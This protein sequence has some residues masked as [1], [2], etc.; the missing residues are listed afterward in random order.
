MKTLQ[1]L[2]VFFGFAYFASILASFYFIQIPLSKR[3]A[4][5][6]QNLNWSLWDNPGILFLIGLNL[7]IPICSY[8]HAMKKSYIA[9][10][11][12]LIVGGFFAFMNIFALLIGTTFEGHIWIGISPTIFASA[13]MVL[14]FTNFI[15]YLNA[16]QQSNQ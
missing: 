12:I 2:E 6:N 3:I 8:L 13:T 14:A 16:R 11:A 10:G 1:R 7:L 15:L 5:Q 4:E 9:F